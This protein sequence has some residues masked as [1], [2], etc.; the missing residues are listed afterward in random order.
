MREFK[1]KHQT[2]GRISVVSSND[3]WHN[4]T[5]VA[6]LTNA[7][8]TRT[9]ICLLIHRQRCINDKDNEL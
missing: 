9:T 5:S 7:R 4:S 6:S 3:K 1:T 8:H 2:S